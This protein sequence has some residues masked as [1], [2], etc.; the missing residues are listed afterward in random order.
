MDLTIIVLTKDNLNELKNTLES[1]EIHC[2]GVNVLIIDGSKNKLEYNKSLINNLKKENYYTYEYKPLIKGIYPSMNYAIK[3][4]ITEYLMFLNAGD[5]L[6]NSPKQIVL[7]LK[8]SDN[9]C[10]FSSAVIL[11]NLK[12]RLYISPPLGIKKFHL[13]FLLGQLPIH[14]S[15]IISTRWSKKNLYP[16]NCQISSDNVIKKKIISSKKFFFSRN[17]LV[18]FSLG[19]LSS[20]LSFKTLILYLK[21]NELFI[22]RKLV[23]IFRFIIGNLF[24][25]KFLALRVKLINFIVS[26]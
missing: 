20:S 19:G 4:V 17:I 14:Q 21:S 13:W 8:N 18:N 15:M 11:N 5:N 23:L 24:G 9:I 22:I 3:L 16:T 6:L 12:Q 7:N 10:G 26:L 25:F 2:E 1:I